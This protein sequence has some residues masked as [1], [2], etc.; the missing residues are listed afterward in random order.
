MES[1]NELLKFNKI[2]IEKVSMLEYTRP[3]ME[4]IEKNIER[5]RSMILTGLRQIGKTTLLK[6]VLKNHSNESLFILINSR[7]NLEELESILNQA[8]FTNKKTIIL[9]DEIQELD[10][11]GKWIV[12]IMGR[13]PATYILSGSASV[14]SINTTGSARFHN[15]VITPL[16]YR[17]YIDFKKLEYSKHN[18]NEY[19]GIN[20][21][22][23]YINDNVV[24][25]NDMIYERYMETYIYQDMRRYE[26]NIK[27]SR[28][29]TII[30]FFKTNTSGETIIGDLIDSQDGSKAKQYNVVLQHMAALEKYHVIKVIKRQ[31][32]DGDI[33]KS[34]KVYLNPH[35]YLI[36]NKV[37]FDDLPGSKKG[38]FLE[39]FLLFYGYV[40]SSYLRQPNNAKKYAKQEIDFCTNNK[41]IEVK[42][43]NKMNNIKT[44]LNKMFLEYN[45]KGLAKEIISL[46][47]VATIK[48]IKNVCF[49]DLLK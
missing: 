40:P 4:E 43:T 18:F 17:E 21:I 7:T 1:Y 26:K 38:Y 10:G 36:L 29:D 41:W 39:S 3:A 49:W 20:A 5:D 28:L 32:L 35:L 31:N 12:E 34:Y 15:I 13:Y 33:G 8:V 24:N 2:L 25:T 47:S 30:N 19:A 27:T 9:L 45:K 46:S 48:N 14:D 16:S 6:Q 11:W 23:A 42:A 37:N 44:G 22:F